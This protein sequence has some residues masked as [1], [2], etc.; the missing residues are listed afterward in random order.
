MILEELGITDELKQLYSSDFV[1]ALPGRVTGEGT[2]IYRVA[3]EQGERFCRVS[4]SFRH[5]AVRKADFPVVGDWVALRRDGDVIEGLLQR[6]RYLSRK[7]AGDKSEEQVLAANVDLVCIVA[8]LDGG[9]NFTR[10]GIERYLALAAESG[11]RTLLVL[12]KLDLCTDLASVL[13]EAEEAA[14]GVPVILTSI[15]TGDGIQELAG[16]VGTGGTAVLVGPSGVGKSSLI[17]FLAGKD[18]L[19]TGVQREQDRRGRHTSTARNL[20][21]LASGGCLIDTPGLREL[22]LWGGEESLNTVFSEIDLL[23]DDCRFRDCSHLEEPGCAVLKAVESGELP[24]ERYRSYL[25]LRKELE[26]LR[27]RT[28]YQARQDEERKWKQISK[29]VRDI[30]K[31]KGRK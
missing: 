15:L 3:V 19:S 31:Y 17:N 28:D 12:N 11:A 22:Q 21:V 25:D 23:A 4:G 10:R 20:V 5:H 7:S 9:R 14:S 26:Y 16:A 13:A 29:S 27:R 24:E 2:H 8:G 30:Y 18:V 6:R 1:D